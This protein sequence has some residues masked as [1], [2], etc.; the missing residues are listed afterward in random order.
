MVV[1]TIDTGIDYNHPDLAASVWSSPTSFT[2]SYGQ[3][4]FNCPAGAHGYSPNAATSNGC[5]PMDLDG[6]GTHVAGIIGAVGNNALGVAGVNW[7]VQL[8][9]CNFNDAPFA[10]DGA[11]ACLDFIKMEKAPG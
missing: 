2:Q 6:H 4:T 7:N 10:L 8:L 5:D 11:V 9:A 1:A 3:Y